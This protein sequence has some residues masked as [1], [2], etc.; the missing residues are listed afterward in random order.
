MTY[1]YNSWKGWFSID[2]EIRSEDNYKYSFQKQTQMVNIINGKYLRIISKTDSRYFY[3][4]Q[5]TLI[6]HFP[7]ETMISQSI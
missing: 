6:N 7:N 4:D 5:W 3:K 1:W 2:Q